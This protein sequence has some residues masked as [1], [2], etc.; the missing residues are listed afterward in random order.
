MAGNP[1]RSRN[2]G[3]YLALGAVGVEMVVPIVAGAFLDSNLGWTPW[4]TLGGVVFGFAI[5]LIHLT[6]MLRRIN[7]PP[8]QS[9]R[10]EP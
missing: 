2:F 8:Q 1:F 6:V 9:P 3:L 5:S 7:K 4:A 10:D